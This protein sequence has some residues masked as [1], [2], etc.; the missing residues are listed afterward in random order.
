SRQPLAPLSSAWETS[1]TRKAPSSSSKQ[2][3][4]PHSEQPV[5]DVPI[6]DDMNISNSKDT[7]TV[8][9]SM[10]KTRPDW[11]KPVPEE[12]RLET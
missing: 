2:K 7:D 4:V 9:L 6:P 12:D 10:I 5:K 3:S 1:D 8:H 11:L